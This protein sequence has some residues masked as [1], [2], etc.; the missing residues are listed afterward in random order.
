MKEY[1]MSKF[2]RSDIVLELLKQRTDP[3]A[4]QRSCWACYSGAAL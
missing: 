4:D 3:P 2:C 1:Q